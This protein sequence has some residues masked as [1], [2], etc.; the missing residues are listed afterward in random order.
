MGLKG[1]QWLITTWGLLRQAKDLKGFFRF[2]RTEYGTLELSC[3]QNQYGR[4]VE[5]CEYHGGAQCGGIRIPEEFRGKNWNHF[6]KELNSFFPGKAVPVKN[7]VGKSRNSKR[8]SNL[9]G[10]PDSILA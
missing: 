9:D 10:K 1:L 7:Q 5:I 4:F 2:L 8:N 6:V 3:L